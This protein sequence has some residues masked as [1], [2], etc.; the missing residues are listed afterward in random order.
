[1]N[2]EDKL[3]SSSSPPP[4]V[5]KVFPFYDCS[6][7][8][9][10]SIHQNI[11][12]KVGYFDLFT[13]LPVQWRVV[14]ARAHHLVLDICT[15]LMVVQGVQPQYRVFLA[16]FLEKGQVL[17]ASLKHVSARLARVGS[18]LD[19]EVSLTLAGF[20]VQV[21]GDPLPLSLK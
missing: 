3:L 6:T 12:L 16:L 21:V 17:L 4:P 20:T 7:Q 18:N 1:M 11:T 2:P 19:P 15:T 14:R 13:H 5:L 8:L 9:V 10:F